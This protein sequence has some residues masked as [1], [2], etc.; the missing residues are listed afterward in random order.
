MIDFVLFWSA[1]LYILSSSLVFLFLLSVASCNFTCITLTLFSPVFFLAIFHSQ[2]IALKF[3]ILS[4]EYYLHV[5]FLLWFHLHYNYLILNC[6]CLM[7]INYHLTYDKVRFV[8]LKISYSLLS[9]PKYAFSCSLISCNL[10][11]L[12]F[13]ELTYQGLFYSLISM[14]LL[15]ISFMLLFRLSSASW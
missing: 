9:K 11:Q 2:L 1:F 14:G 5:V 6:Y 13:Q 8:L 4:E 12:L 10:L 15:Y 7:S 3:L